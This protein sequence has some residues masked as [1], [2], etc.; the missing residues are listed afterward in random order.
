MCG[1]VTGALLAG[2]VW[3][4]RLRVGQHLIVSDKARDLFLLRGLGECQGGTRRRY[5]CKHA[6]RTGWLREMALELPGGA[7]R[8]GE[9]DGGSLAVHCG[10]DHQSGLPSSSQQLGEVGAV[11]SDKRH[12][13]NSSIKNH[14][15]VR[16]EGCHTVCVQ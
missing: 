14:K 12:P 8:G 9:G 6:G 15:D 5:Q 16:R 11:K 7:G 13:F 3:V 4:G 2:G 10:R 1:R